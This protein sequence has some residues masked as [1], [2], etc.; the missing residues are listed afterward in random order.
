M[1]EVISSKESPAIQPLR[2]IYAHGDLEMALGWDCLV[3]HTTPA[4]G[5]S[6]V[7]CNGNICNAY[8][9]NNSTR[10]LV[11]NKEDAE[12][13]ADAINRFFGKSQTL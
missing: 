13:N 2:G 6:E 11:V 3:A 8:I 1:I 9:W 4:D 12:G 5:V 10:G 7:L